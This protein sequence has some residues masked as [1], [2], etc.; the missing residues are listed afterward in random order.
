M[1]IMER[2]DFR[3][4]FGSDFIFLN[5]EEYSD[6]LRAKLALEFLQ[7]YLK[8]NQYATLSDVKI[9]VEMTVGMDEKVER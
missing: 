3:N 1:N 8:N 6:L 5:K 7:K 2:N 4:D 9:T